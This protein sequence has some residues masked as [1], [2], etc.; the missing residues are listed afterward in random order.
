MIQNK[1]PVYIISKG[2]ADSMYTSRSLNEMG[3]QHT[4]AVEPKDVERYR[5]AFKTVGITTASLLELPLSD[6]GISS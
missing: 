3:V 5:E 1:Y 6:H 4:I 2:R